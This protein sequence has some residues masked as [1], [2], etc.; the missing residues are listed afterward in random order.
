IPGTRAL[1]G[2]F[3]MVGLRTGETQV[4][5]ILDADRPCRTSDLVAPPVGLEQAHFPRQSASL[6][7]SPGLL[8]APVLTVNGAAIPAGA[9]QPRIVSLSGAGTE[10]VP[11]NDYCVE[12]S[13]NP[14]A[15][16]EETF[17]LSYQGVIPFLDA[18]GGDLRPDPSGTA[19]QILLSAQAAG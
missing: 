9:D 12:I 5:E 8:T 3:A 16:R 15:I 11:D 1:R 7:T 13:P 2:L 18:N 6:T 19:G 17:T 14:L 10:C 4:I